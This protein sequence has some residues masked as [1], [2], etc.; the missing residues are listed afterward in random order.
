MEGIKLRE[1]VFD[2][3]RDLTH[4]FKTREIDALPDGPGHRLVGLEQVVAT[5]R[6]IMDGQL[7]RGVEPAEMVREADDRAAYQLRYYEFPLK[8]DGVI[9]RVT[10]AALYNNIARAMAQRLEWLSTE[11]SGGSWRPV[12]YSIE[13]AAYAQLSRESTGVNPAMQMSL[14]SDQDV[15]EG[16]STP[17]LTRPVTET[18]HKILVC[19]AFCDVIQGDFTDVFAARFNKEGGADAKFA[20]TQELR[21]M[22]P[23]LRRMREAAKGL[24]RDFYEVETDPED[25]GMSPPQVHRLLDLASKGVRAAELASIFSVT[26]GFVEKLLVRAPQTAR[27]GPACVDLGL[28][29]PPEG[30]EEPKKRPKG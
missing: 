21:H 5:L 9:G 10:P 16:R 2:R 3:A 29:E 13:R 14:P 8:E 12:A 17:Q 26:P 15:R 19:V 23:R 30:A 6:T 18:K 24:I 1:E 28:V 7:F 20:A 25:L 11:Q 27:Y 4:V 22:Q